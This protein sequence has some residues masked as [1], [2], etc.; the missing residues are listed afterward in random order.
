[1][2]KKKRIYT[3]EQKEQRK[4]KFDLKQANRSLEQIAEDIAKKKI[5]KAKYDEKNRGKKRIYTAEQKVRNNARN[6][7]WYKDNTEKSKEN[8]IRFKE[9][10]LGY[11]PPCVKED[12]A[13][14]V[15][16]HNLGYIAVYA[17]DDYNGTGA[18]YVG[19]T[20]NLYKRMSNHRSCG[21]L[22]TDTHR[23]LGCFRT[24]EQALVFERIKHDEGF[25]GDA[26]TATN[27]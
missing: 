25:H 1:M 10:N 24:R 23:V 17:I 9:K 11:V 2:E 8:S 4:I 16:R 3:E 14:W 19:Q 21:K 15:E 13:Y 6:S 5:Y 7:K 26:R 22:N 12:P 18:V 20:G 27:T